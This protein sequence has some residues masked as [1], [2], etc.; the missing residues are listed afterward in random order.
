M[1]E[2]TLK[3]KYEIKELELNALLEVTQAIN[4]NVPEDSIYKIFNF[5]LR[6]NLNIRKLALFVLDDDWHCKVNFGT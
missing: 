3:N 1:T 2:L 4:N 5:I 6:S